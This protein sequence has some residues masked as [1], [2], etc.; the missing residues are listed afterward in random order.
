MS[1]E[2]IEKA[3]VSLSAKERAKIRA[4]IEEL[5]ADI[6]DKQI[7]E[8]ARNGKLDKLFEDAVDDM[9]TGRTTK[10]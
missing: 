5:D 9:R 2:E 1:V 3:I 10:L 7:E 8:D 4:F 6:W